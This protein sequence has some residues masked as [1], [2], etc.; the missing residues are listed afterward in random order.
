MFSIFTTAQKTWVLFTR[1]MDPNDPAF[2]SL[3]DYIK[4]LPGFMGGQHTDPVS[5]GLLWPFDSKEHA[6][7]AHASLSEYGAKPA[8]NII[9]GTLK[10]KHLLLEEKDN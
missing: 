7:A 3:V 10:G 5:Q 2:K 8:P 4:S 9:R 6:K 1:W